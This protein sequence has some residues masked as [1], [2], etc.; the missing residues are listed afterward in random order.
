MTQPHSE[1]QAEPVAPGRERPAR[2]AVVRWLL[3]YLVLSIVVGALCGVLWQ[4]VVRLPTYLVHADGSAATT[5]RGLAAV[6]G[7][8]AWFSLIGVLVSAGLGLVGWRWFRRL[9][10]PAVVAVVLG[11]LTA[12]LLCWGIG[13]LLGPGPLAPRL[14]A[15]KPGDLVPI[16]LTVRAY[17]ALVVWPFGGVL[18]VLLAA[19]LT[20]DP[21]LDR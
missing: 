20:R 10:W 1:V 14:A 19:A 13:Y 21:D 16:T 3:A 6:A 8:D 15:A 2:R 7:A 17:A 18:P 5:E 12:A 9:G 11:T 4:R